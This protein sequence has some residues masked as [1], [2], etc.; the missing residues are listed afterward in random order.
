MLSVYSFHHNKKRYLK[1]CEVET[2]FFC[3]FLTESLYYKVEVCGWK[4][5]RMQE[6]GRV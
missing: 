4:E 1:L 5:V 3:P 2:F 6:A